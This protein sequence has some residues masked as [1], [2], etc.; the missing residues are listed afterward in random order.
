MKMLY[1]AYFA[2]SGG[3]FISLFPAFWAYTRITGK[4]RRHLEERLGVFPPEAVQ[5][6]TGR[7]RIWMHTASLGEVKVAASI[8][9]ALRRMMPGCSLIV[10]TVT[11]HGRKL[12]RETFGEDIPVVYAPIDFVGSIRKALF[13]VR[14]DVMVFV[15][16]EI[17]P[18]WLFEAHRMGIKTAL[19]NGRISVRSIGRYLKL[20]PFFRDV[21]INLDVFSMI[22]A[23]DAER[24]KAMG[25]DP[26]KIEINGNAKYDLLG[27][28]VDPGIESEMREIL[29]L[30]ASDKVFVAGS[31]RNGEEAMLLDA[32]EKILKEFPETILIIAPRHIERIHAIGALVEKRGLGYQLWT[33][34]DKD[35]AKRTEQVVIINAFGE[36]F[37]IYSVGTIV[38]CGGSLVP[39]GGQN[40]LE[41]AAWGKAVFYGPSMENFMDAK[42][43]LEA[44]K[45]GL[46]ISSP[47][48]LAEKA[49]WFLGHP[50]ELKAY[51]ERGRAA[52]L[53][54]KGAGEK[55][56]RVIMRLWESVANA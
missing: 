34:L 9:K 22:R 37:K 44:N 52:V 42:S 54:N 33:D 32:Y 38:F 47:E 26:Q 48:M 24:I 56:A 55:H 10:S 27:A 50:E 35:K 7:P 30:E 8:V 29:N 53:K 46:P 41:P 39:L 13:T 36:L 15:E 16:T 19:I 23:G 45:A 31:T 12:A 2:L 43:L 6:L 11:E 20:R 17:W 4:Y 18:A 40:P 3:L 5:C 1:G 21:L 25:A 14:P 28:T 51:G 49:V